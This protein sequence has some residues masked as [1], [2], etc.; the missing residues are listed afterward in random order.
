LNSIGFLT[1]KKNQERM[2]F[3]EIALHAPVTLDV[4]R[5]TPLDIDP[6][7]EL[8]HGS[9]FNHSNGKWENSV[10]DIPDYIYDRCFYNQDSFSRKCEPI[11]T[12]LKQRPG[13]TFLGYGL[14]N[15][16]EVYEALIQESEV[17]PYLP[18]TTPIHTFT[19]LKRILMK[20][21]SIVLK[22]ISG[23]QGNG[24][25]HL[26][27]L[28]NEITLQTQKKGE[29]FHKSFT[30][31][32]EFKTFMEKLLQETNFLCQP[33]LTMQKGN[34]PFDIRILMQKDETGQWIEQGRGVRVGKENGLVSNLHNGGDVIT[35][36]ELLKDFSP[37]IRS[38]LLEEIE[39]ITK[40]T[41]TLLENKFGRLFELG[42]D[43]GITKE[44][45]VWLLDI[46]SKP[47]RKVISNT[48]P[49]KK[50]QLFQSPINYARFLKNNVANI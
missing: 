44:G 8:V 41:P 42:L 27:L 15:K 5:F 14:P 22:P 46:N 26:Q 45:A 10:F 13:T 24:I 12:W 32:V 38:V 40:Q 29:D 11:V 23:S 2:Y 39:S 43:I 34:K 36:E 33:Y 49:S 21:N 3:T 16:W 35:F 4:V 7:T 25:I 47:G 50:I 19:K 28:K 31:L 9:K 30:S 17:S 18:D 48:S 6:A 20:E 1:V 37:Q